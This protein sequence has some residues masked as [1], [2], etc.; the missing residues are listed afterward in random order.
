MTKNVKRCAVNCFA[1][2]ASMSTPGYITSG[3]ANR[4]RL[5]Y[6]GDRVALRP[7]VYADVTLVSGAPSVTKYTFQALVHGTW[8]T[9]TNGETILNFSASPANGTTKPFRLAGAINVDATLP[10]GFVSGAYEMQ[11]VVTAIFADGHTEQVTD[12][13]HTLAVLNERASPYARG[14]TL[15]GAPKLY[16]YFHANGTVDQTKYLAATGDGGEITYPTT[17]ACS[18]GTTDPPGVFSLINSHDSLGVPRSPER[19]YPDSSKEVWGATNGQTA[20]YVVDRTAKD[21]VWFTDDSLGPEARVLTISDPLRMYHGAHT[22]I[23]LHYDA[24]GHLAKIVEPRGNDNAP[25]SG[26][27]TLVSVDASGFLRKWTDPDGDSTKFGY[28]SSGRLDSLT[29]RNGNV[30]TYTFEPITSKLATASTPKV[31]LDFNST[32]TLSTIHLVTTYTPWQTVGVPTGLTSTTPATP[33][34]AD[35]V[36]SMV[37]TAGGDTTQFTA[38]RW[39][40]PLVSTT[41]MGIQMSVTYDQNGYPATVTHPVGGVDEYQYSG[42]LLVFSQPAGQVATSYQYGAFDQPLQI[43]G[44]NQPTQQFF[45]GTRGH[46]DST[47]VGG[48]TT[49]YHPDA[50][51]RD[52]SMVDGVR[53]TT[54]FV[55]D[56]W[57]GNVDTVMLK[58]SQHFTARRF[59]RFGRD[60]VVTLSAYSN[61]SQITT[62]VTTT[63]YD[64]LNRVDS[65]FDGVHANPTIYQRDGLNVTS[66]TNPKGEVFSATYNA[67]NL[68]VTQTDPANR[69]ETTTYTSRLTTATTTN[70]Q[71]QMVKYL[72]DL[73]G[74]VTHVHRPPSFTGELDTLE[75]IT[76]SKLGD[77]VNAWNPVTREISYLSPS[78]GNVD[79]STTIFL[80]AGNRSYKRTYFYDSHDRVDSMTTTVSSNVTGIDPYTRKFLYNATT[81]TL[82]HVVVGPDTISFRRDPVFRTDTMLFTGVSGSR[83]DA[84]TSFGMLGNTTWTGFNLYRG[85]GYDNLSHVIE[86]DHGVVKPDSVEFYSYD[87]VGELQQRQIGQWNDN[88]T[89]CPGNQLYGNGCTVNETRVVQTDETDGYRFDAAGSLD[90]VVVGS[91]DTIGTVGS[92]GRLTAWGALT[93]TVDSDGDRSGMTSGSTTR[94]YTWSADGRLAQIVSGDTTR[95]YDYDNYGQLAR[96]TTNGTVD[97]YY[98]WDNNQLMAILDGS[99]NTRLSEFAYYPGT[100]DYPLIRIKGAKGSSTV[101]Y[102]ALD[103]G[104]NV[105]GQFNS[106]GIE[107]SIQY[108]PWG[109]AR[110]A[111]TSDTTPLRWKSLLY[112]DGVTSL[113]YMRARWYDPVTRRFLLPDPLGLSGGINQ[114]A[115]GGGDPINSTDASGTFFCGN[116]EFAVCDGSGWSDIPPGSGDPGPGPTAPGASNGP[117]GNGPAPAS[118]GGI[119][120]PTCNLPGQDCAFTPN[121]GYC[122]INLPSCTAGDITGS[123]PMFPPPGTK[124]DS[125]VAAYQLCQ[126]VPTACIPG[127]TSAI[128]GS[129]SIFENTP[130]VGGADPMATFN[131]YAALPNKPTTGLF[132]CLG[133]EHYV[134]RGGGYYGWQDLWR[135]GVAV[136]VIKAYLAKCK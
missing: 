103:A 34:E 60:S 18:C 15:S 28:D 8:A 38:D 136:Q 19:D 135:L 114:Y 45:I 97:R 90:T 62:Q 69:T 108:D 32:G 44:T 124:A 7:V 22:H 20:G 109:N 117:P 39:G 29:D 125:T 134:P 10:S 48:D 116:G 49:R 102:Y 43:S 56:S 89:S 119:P 57:T 94:Q 128:G 2:T 81:G 16:S 64:L 118:S 3:A 106:S 52:T 31:P 92:D 53:D 51:L 5:V 112:E 54:R 47:V 13:S 24:N 30:T 87:G 14:W 99:A 101:H 107:D 120:G 26:R 111:T 132:G 9:F 73:L 67:V 63:L 126:T 83:I 59:D 110:V 77:T 91:A 35:L 104:G 70:R 1:M 23:T 121:Q 82:D 76:Y 4:V 129:I 17:N 21:T 12:T 86:L 58:S 71:G 33:V 100:A 68:P 78:T 130:N 85:Y 36:Q 46:I 66:L 133:I 131:P 65:V 93:F 105:I 79:S 80:L 115:F 11:L 50:R 127:P 42:P 84:Y 95:I 72:Y 25:D 61:T 37:V 122:S 88:I 41:N 113:Y 55:Y 75:I 98:L 96:R 6:N 74:R 40:Q 123:N 27:V